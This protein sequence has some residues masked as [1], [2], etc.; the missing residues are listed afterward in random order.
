MDEGVQWA[1]VVMMLRIQKERGASL[2]GMSDEDYLDLYGLNLRRYKMMKPQ[3]IIMHPAPS[4]EASKS[5]TPFVE[6][7][8][9][10]IFKQMENGVLVRKAVIKRA[11]G[12]S[13]FKD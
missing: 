9:S 12:Y 10:R 13:Y 1:D 8:Q 5:T 11:F 4:I 6:C 2:E 7:P 3:A